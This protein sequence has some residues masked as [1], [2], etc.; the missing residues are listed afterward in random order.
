MQTV[1][2]SP[3]R[4]AVVVLAALGLLAAS[5]G[6]KDD[7]GTTPTCVTDMTDQGI[8]VD[9]AGA[10]LDGGCTPYPTCRDD[11][12]NLLPPQSCCIGPDAGKNADP[13]DDQKQCLCAYGVGHCDNVGAGGAGATT[14]TTTTTTTSAGGSGAGGK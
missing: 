1:P 4:L 11:Q 5:M 13:T 6:C 8:A 10:H 9:D 12:G 7:E 2:V 14:T 3:A